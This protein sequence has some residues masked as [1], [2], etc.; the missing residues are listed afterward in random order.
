MTRS[1]V[2]IMVCV[3]AIVAVGCDREADAGIATQ[4]IDQ[5]HI[6]AASMIDAGRYIAIIGGCN[7]CHTPGWDRTHGEIPEEQWLL[8]S[9]VGYHG[10]WGTSYAGNLRV[11]FHGIS[12]DAW[13]AYARD[14]HARP[15]MPSM[16]INRM[17]EQDLR[18]LYQYVRSLEPVGERKPAALPPGETP[19]GPYFDFH[20]QNLPA[21]AD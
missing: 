15:P 10:P 4:T 14:W 19:A 16:N 7:D 9:D 1:L 6:A 12:E 11:F 13:V 3:M 8:G 2:T 17:T 5:P 21:E 20:V 18:A